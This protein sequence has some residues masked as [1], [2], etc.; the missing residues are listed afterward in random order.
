MQFLLTEEEYKD[1]QASISSDGKFVEKE[2]D[3][4][5]LL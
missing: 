5:L 4:S 1:L 3:K 2:P